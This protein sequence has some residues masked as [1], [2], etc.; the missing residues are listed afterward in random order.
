MGIWNF[1][2]TTDWFDLLSEEEAAMAD[3]AFV[4]VEE[5]RMMTPKKGKA[6]L[7]DYIYSS[8]LSSIRA[9]VENAFGSIQ[10]WAICRDMFVLAAEYHPIVWEV[11]ASL[12]NLKKRGWQL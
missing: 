1:I 10:Q 3:L 4:G 6:S 5:I 11:C 7:E 2:E 8:E 12:H 9:K